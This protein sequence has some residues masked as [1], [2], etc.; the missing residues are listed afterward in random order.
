MLRPGRGVLP[1]AQRESNH[2]TPLSLVQARK[3]L[4]AICFLNTLRTR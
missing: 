2:E 4:Q 3:R 1:D